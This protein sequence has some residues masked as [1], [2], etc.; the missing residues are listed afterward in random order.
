MQVLRETTDLGVKLADA[1]TSALQTHDKVIWLV[2]GGSNIGISV[3]A[4]LLLCRP[5]SDL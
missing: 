4:S 1:L 3:E 5:T 2:P